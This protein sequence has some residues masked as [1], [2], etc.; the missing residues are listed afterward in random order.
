MTVS[1]RNAPGVLE[2]PGNFCNQ[3]SGILGAGLLAPSLPLLAP[4]LLK[5]CSLLSVWCVYWVHSVQNI[6]VEVVFA[7][8]VC[9]LREGSTLFKV[10]WLLGHD[11]W[12][13]FGLISESHC[14]WSSIPWIFGS[15]YFTW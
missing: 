5:S 13:L 2:S 12:Q 10:L 1:W 6:M 15:S 4:A 8:N 14:I 7:R 3:E 9:D 11:G